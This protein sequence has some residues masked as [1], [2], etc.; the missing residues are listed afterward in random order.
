MRFGAL[1]KAVFAQP[2]VGIGII[3]GAGGTVRLPRLIGQARALEIILGCGDI[4]AEEAERYGYINRAPAG[5]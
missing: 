2:E 5:R 1:G 3:P 4:S